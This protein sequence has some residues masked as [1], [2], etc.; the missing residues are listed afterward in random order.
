MLLDR[1][2]A[3]PGA[4]TTSQSDIIGVIFIRR[5][6]PFDQAL[7]EQILE[8]AARCWPYRL[9]NM[10]ELTTLLADRGE[11][12]ILPTLD[13]LQREDNVTFVNK[14]HAGGVLRAFVGLQLTLQGRK[15]REGDA[16]FDR[17]LA[18]RILRHLGSKWPKQIQ[19]LAA[20]R[21]SMVNAENSDDDWLK[22][23]R[24]LE[25]AGFVEIE[26]AKH[27]DFGH[28]LVVVG[29]RATIRG[30]DIARTLDQSQ[31]LNF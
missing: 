31:V 20:M 28:L 12:D 22:A 23:L 15:G 7:A 21:E 11:D 13:G 25:V 27:N 17:A 10:S 29:I 1:T 26:H 14:V 18:T 16:Q 2:S 30:R 24:A 6:M 4:A 9:L 5:L 19:N 8:V 3:R